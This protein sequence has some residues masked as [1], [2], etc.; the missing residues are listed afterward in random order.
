MRDLATYH[1]NA[2][3]AFGRNAFPFLFGVPATTYLFV[4]LS[5]IYEG[6]SSG[7]GRATTKRG[8][9]L[10][11]LFGVL[12]TGG[13]YTGL[14]FFDGYAGIMV[15]GYVFVAMGCVVATCV[16]LSLVGLVAMGRGGIRLA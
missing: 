14:Y 4:L 8:Y 15:M 7:R 2:A 5:L 11:M 13:V 3:S 6:I 10:L 9:T 12:A 16:S 1:S